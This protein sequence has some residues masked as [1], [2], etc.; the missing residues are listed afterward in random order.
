MLDGCFT[1]PASVAPAGMQ[2]GSDDSDVPR[3]AADTLH[4]KKRCHGMIGG[5][6]GNAI[7]SLICRSVITIPYDVGFKL[8]TEERA[9]CDGPGGGNQ[10]QLHCFLDSHQS[11]RSPVCCR[12]RVA[13]VRLSR[14]GERSRIRARRREDE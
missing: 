10:R 9:G 4:R 7:V 3:I 2:H 5:F 11:L 12:L 14:R 6:H 1:G 13:V 8:Q